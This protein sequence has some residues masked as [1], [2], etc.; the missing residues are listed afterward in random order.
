MRFKYGAVY[1]QEHTVKQEIDSMSSQ[2]VVSIQGVGFTP[3]KLCV[4]C[5]AVADNLK[6]AI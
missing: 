4:Q 3:P 5:V 1:S 2:D 6:M